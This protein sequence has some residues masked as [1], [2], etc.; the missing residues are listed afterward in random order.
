MEVKLLQ[1]VQKVKVKLRNANRAFQERLRE[2]AEAKAQED[3][4]AV[5]KPVGEA[6][7]PQNREA[8]TCSAL[9]DLTSQGRQRLEA[10]YFLQIY[11]QGAA[12]QA[13][14]GLHL[15]T[16]LN[17]VVD[18]LLAMARDHTAASVNRFSSTFL[19][20]FAAQ[21]YVLFAT[22]V[23]SA[24]Q[25][26]HATA[27]AAEDAPK[28]ISPI[29]EAAFSSR[30]P[31]WGANAWP[32]LQHLRDCLELS[33]NGL[34]PVL[35]QCVV[36]LV[37]VLGNGATVT[38]LARAEL[39]QALCLLLFLL[40]PTHDPAL[41]LA[42]LGGAKPLHKAVKRLRA[43]PAVLAYAEVPVATMALL[44]HSPYL[45][46]MGMDN[47]RDWGLL[48][49]SIMSDK[50]KAAVDESHSLIVAARRCRGEHDSYAERL[51]AHSLLSQEDR[52]QHEASAQ[53]RD[54]AGCQLCQEGIQLL[55]SWSAGV[56][57]MH[58]WKAVRSGT[59]FPSAPEED[60]RDAAR[61]LYTVGECEALLELLACIKGVAAMLQAAQGWLQPQAQEHVYRHLMRFVED[62]APTALA[63]TPSPEVQ[64]SLEAI[65]NAARRSKG[66]VQQVAV[67]RTP[68]QQLSP[69]GSLISRLYSLKMR[70]SFS[71]PSAPPQPHASGLS[72]DAL[73]GGHDSPEGHTVPPPAVHYPLI[74][75]IETILLL[76]PPSGPL[77]MFKR[78]PALPSGLVTQLQQLHKQL[79][80][81]NALSLNTTIPEASNLAGMRMWGSTGR[82]RVMTSAYADLAVMSEQLIAGLSL[83][84]FSDH[85]RLAA[86]M[87]SLPQSPTSN[88][89][90]L[91]RWQG[92]LSQASVPFL[93]G[94]RLELQQR[95][96]SA[97]QTLMHQ[98]A[99]ALAQCYQG[100]P[101]TSIG[102]LRDE[103]FVETKRGTGATRGLTT[104]HIRDFVEVIGP[105]GVAMLLGHLLDDLD[106]L[107]TDLPPVM[108]AVQ[109]QA[110]QQELATLFKQPNAA[111][112]F[113]MLCELQPGAEDDQPAMKQLL[114]TLSHLGN[115]LVLLRNLDVVIA[116]DASTRAFL[117][118]APLLGITPDSTGMLRRAAPRELSMLRAAIAAVRNNCQRNCSIEDLAAIDAAEDHVRN[119][120][121]ACWEVAVSGSL[122]PVVMQRLQSAAGPL[123]DAMASEDPLCNAPESAHSPPRSPGSIPLTGCQ[124]ITWLVAALVL[125]EASSKSTSVPI[126]PAAMQALIPRMA[127]WKAKKAD[128]AALKAPGDKPKGVIKGLTDGLVWGVAAT[129]VLSKQHSLYCL[130]DIGG[131]A[132]ELARTAPPDTPAFSSPNRQTDLTSGTPKSDQSLIRMDPPLFEAPHFD[133]FEFPALPGG[134]ANHGGVQSPSNLMH[135]KRG[136]RMGLH[137]K[138]GAAGAILAQHLSHQVCAP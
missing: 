84:V 56:M 89:Y 77:N 85:K 26:V 104:A 44:Q 58:A 52:R 136:V 47:S 57:D 97:V 88:H 68:D 128:W 59:P 29:R 92:L 37:D 83:Q 130:N 93:P 2:R 106:L 122:L 66:A 63:H 25:H 30:S 120:E 34:A 95:L 24:A 105:A 123:G 115:G 114:A 23:L 101:A 11:D 19:R 48:L 103:V 46:S 137:G 131:K 124:S 3:K 17:G 80:A 45:L 96:S 71:G 27:Q 31:W 108:G 16:Y 51:A 110:S 78:S 81:C 13:E 129:L 40:F 28:Q 91:R 109:R 42:A 55:S 21:L 6:M 86:D 49:P 1:K 39:L 126:G 112:F 33:M 15:D 53:E 35:G 138:R 22:D 125:G 14:E 62:S 111:A 113:Q 90:K 61:R 82:E 118:A 10:L 5:L 60:S 20:A 134:G 38:A 116:A 119:V 41:G 107:V 94:E 36:H 135:G 87:R 54:A 8:E 75:A 99:D 127:D 76:A 102:M 18:V 64:A 100:V 4:K 98:N 69:N 43:H 73:S 9:Q 70:R 50:A 132:L 67:Q 32:V 65:L 79:L 12:V 74:H 117:V 133:L 121:N 72:P 7:L